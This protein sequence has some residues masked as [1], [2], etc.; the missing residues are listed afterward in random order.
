MSFEWVSQ[1]L[2][3]CNTL[4]EYDVHGLQVVV[5]P[6]PTCLGL[7][8]QTDAIQQSHVTVALLGTH[9]HSD[10]RH[11]HK[12]AQ[13]ALLICCFFLFLILDKNMAGDY[14]GHSLHF[15]LASSSQSLFAHKHRGLSL[16]H[17]YTHTCT[18]TRTNTH[19]HTHRQS[20][21]QMWILSL[22]LGR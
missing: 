14:F 2:G 8:K 1:A 15:P 17:N 21:M 22:R 11:L 9:P 5:L 4:H 16:L 7:A 6:R 12:Q 3:A 13:N 18:H 10:P 20:L 19:I